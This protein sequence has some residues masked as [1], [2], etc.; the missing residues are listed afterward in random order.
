MKTDIKT[1]TKNNNKQ[2]KSYKN[3]EK[4]MKTNKRL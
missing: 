2:F 1:N 3:N 4:V